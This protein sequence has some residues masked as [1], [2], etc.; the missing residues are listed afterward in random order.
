MVMMEKMK[1][2]PKKAG[3]K[4]YY[5]SGIKIWKAW[6]HGGSPIDKINI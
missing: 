5:Q 3:E 6:M 2:E 1:E 4:Y